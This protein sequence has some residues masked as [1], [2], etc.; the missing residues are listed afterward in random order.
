[1]APDPAAELASLLDR[2][3]AAP[4]EAAAVG[5]F[6]RRFV[7][8]HYDIAHAVTILEAAYEEAISNPARPLRSR[9]ATS[10][11]GFMLRSMV[12]STGRRIRLALSARMHG[13]GL[14]SPEVP[15]A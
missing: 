14:A 15:H 12:V 10:L 2:L 4:E 8:A 3:L 13:A 11:L 1:V 7:R 9:L 5:E 6:G